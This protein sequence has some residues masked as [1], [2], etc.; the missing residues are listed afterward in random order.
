MI[1]QNYTAKGGL[2][3]T[4]GVSTMLLCE[5]V[6]SI[7]VLVE[8]LNPATE[9]IR[10]FNLLPSPDNFCSYVHFLDHGTDGSEDLV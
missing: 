8:E 2:D 5:G 3:F 4:C 9:S 7:Y 10:E 1:T 6:R